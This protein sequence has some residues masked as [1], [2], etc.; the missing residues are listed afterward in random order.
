MKT[1]DAKK[2]I[3]GLLKAKSPEPITPQEVNYGNKSIAFVQIYG[4]FSNLVKNGSVQMNQSEGKK[5]YSILDETKLND[6]PAPAAKE[7]A[8]KVQKHKE[9][10]DEKPV[11]KAS[12]RDLTTYRFN[13]SEGLNKGRLALAIIKEY[14]REKKPS[15][16]TLLE[17]FPDTIVPPYGVCKPVKIAKEMS[18]ERARFFIKPEEEI[19]LR[20]CSICVSNQWTVDRIQQVISIAKKQ[21]GYKI[22]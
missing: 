13:N 12:G 21:L 17:M 20:D 15:F 19:K 4:I 14:A 3:I 9:E 10:E 7:K 5:F 8:V 2:I 16:K 22:K 11:Q 1:E 6:D 18:K